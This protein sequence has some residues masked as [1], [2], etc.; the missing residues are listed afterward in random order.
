MIYYFFNKPSAISS[1]DGNV[2]CNDFGN[3]CLEIAY[4]DIPIGD[5]ICDRAY[6]ASTLFFDLQINKPIA[7][8][9][10]FVLSRSFI[11]AMYPASCPMSGKSNSVVFI[12]S[13]TQ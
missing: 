13:T 1:G 9:S 10:V 3:V 6:F 11:M 5:L 7:G 4:S 12:T 8:F 2:S